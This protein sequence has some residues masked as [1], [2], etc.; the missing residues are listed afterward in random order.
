M[1]E[2]DRTLAGP[3]VSRRSVLKGAAAAGAL[4]FAPPLHLAA[5]AA[6]PG[7]TAGAASTDITPANG[8]EMFGY[9]RPDMRVEGVSIRLQAHALVLDDDERK[10]ALV[11][12]DLG[13][14]MVKSAVV[15]RVRHAGFDERTVLLAATHTHAG[16]NDADDW[17]AHQIATAIV[18]ADSRR[19]P[20]RAA[21]ATV[22][23]HDAN[24][25]RSVEAHLANHGMDLT[26]GFGEAHLD[27]HGP[28][29]TRD[30]D[31]RVLR[32]EALNG[33]PI[34]A[35][36]HFSAHPTTYIPSNTTFSA[37]FPGIAT[38]RFARAF[39]GPRPVVMFS[40][41]VEGDLI[42]WFDDYNQHAVADRIGLRVAAAIGRGWQE[43]G[44]RLSSTFPVDARVT[45]ATYAGQEVA[46][47]RRVA[48]YVGYWGASFFGGAKN[49][50]SIFYEVPGTEGRRRPA[51]LADP[52]HGRKIIAAP[53]P[54]SPNLEVQA[55][56]AGDRLLLAV[57]GE[58][59]TE[60]GRR[61]RAAASPAAPDTVTDIAI[62]ALANGFHGYFTTP[63]EYDQQHYEGGHTVF[64]KWSSL[65]L[66]ETHAGLAAALAGESLA[67]PRPEGSAPDP[68]T[69]P[70]GD[71]ADDARLVNPP[72]PV[73]AR[74]ETVT[75]RWDGSPQGRDRLVDEA[76]IVLEREVDGVWRAIDDDYSGWAFVWTED[77]GRYTA[78]YEFGPGH[79]TGRHRFRVRSGRYRLVTS[80][81]EVIRS[82][83]LIVRGAVIES[84]G[85]TLVFH[86]QNPPPDP[87]AHMRT[88]PVVP[89]GGTLRF[90]VDGRE[91]TA[92]WDG[93]R[94]AWV[95][96]AA[97]VRDGTDLT[98]PPGGLVD[99]HGNIS[100][101][102]HI[103]VGE[104][105]PVRWPPPIGPAGGRTPGPFGV[106]TWPP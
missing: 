55:I 16:P 46:P 21:W 26:P 81:F 67:A 86:A 95:A 100:G 13:A 65:L 5:R 102:Q 96:P 49:G 44:S 69:A 20:A 70:T 19:V 84:Q 10:I 18:D 35:W 41:G 72:S 14:P 4:T 90:A 23:L 78:R 22:Q 68:V 37:D 105:R 8:G 60:A 83:G 58:P 52:V 87:E 104:L 6:G 45:T 32:V 33:V 43:A 51:A 98:I 61:M 62:V 36:T 82:S 3:V 24:V 57:P 17:I 2:Q 74:M 85:R 92:R 94:R 103:T 59:T 75:F 12:V 93:E 1:A 11:A 71:G 101:R 15:D 77:R 106:G 27:P 25:N 40:N 76:F 91:R 9:V 28:D 56:R 53:A 47:G 97:N 63:E 30:V 89:A 48:S 66:E 29:H 99:R 88:R 42:T 80:A 31:L 38:R 7:L 64:G 34:A 39:R 79:G 73:V 50:P 54:W